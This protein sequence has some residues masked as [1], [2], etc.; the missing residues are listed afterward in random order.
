MRRLHCW[1]A[2]L[3]TG[4]LLRLLLQAL[5]VLR[6]RVAPAATAAQPGVEPRLPTA[7]ELRLTGSAPQLAPAPANTCT[8]DRLRQTLSEKR[9]KRHKRG[10]APPA[11]GVHMNCMHEGTVLAEEYQGAAASCPSLPATHPGCCI[12]HLALA[13]RRRAPFMDCLWELGAAMRPAAAMLWLLPCSWLNTSHGSSPAVEGLAPDPAVLACD[14]DAWLLSALMLL[15][16]A[17]QKAAAWMFRRHAPAWRPVLWGSSSA[18]GVPGPAAAPAGAGVRACLAVL[19]AGRSNDA[20]DWRPEPGPP[21]KL[22]L[23]SK[24]LPRAAR[25]R[26]SSR[27]CSLQDAKQCTA[28]MVTAGRA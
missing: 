13:M 27:C 28:W 25:S 17:G 1:R 24:S 6:L 8:P 26:I 23:R 22:S 18:A 16:P 2:L 10:R 5:K 21:A 11:V 12:L 15:P 19:A 9:L 3:L 4:C 20:G 7:A 14:T